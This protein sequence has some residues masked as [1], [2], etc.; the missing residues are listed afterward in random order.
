MVVAAL[1]ILSGF[2]DDVGLRN[3]IVAPWAW[4]LRQRARELAAH[5]MAEAAENARVIARLVS[6]VALGE[7]DA[8]TLMRAAASVDVETSER[9]TAIEI[10]AAAMKQAT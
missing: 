3:E 10:L 8:E 6:A 9:D 1:H 4:S 2:A 5:G 7:I